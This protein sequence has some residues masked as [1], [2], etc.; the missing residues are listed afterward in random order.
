MSHTVKTEL[1]LITKTL[2]QCW[3][4]KTGTALTLRK[5]Q[6]ILPLEHTSVIYWNGSEAT[7]NRY[8]G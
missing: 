1:V 8:K 5:M 7:V 2:N 3:F 4:E 6:Y